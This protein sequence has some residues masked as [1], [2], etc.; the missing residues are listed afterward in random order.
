MLTNR[1]GHH[2]RI[3]DKAFQWLSFSTVVSVF[4]LVILGGVVRVTESGLG[5]PDWPLCHGK[6]IPDVE[7]HA[8]IEYSHRLLASLVT[9]LVLTMTVVAW[10]RYKHKPLI[11]SASVLSLILILVQAG[12]GAITVL[13]ELAGDVVMAHLALAE[14]L[15]FII[16]LI[17][18][19]TLRR[20]SVSKRRSNGLPVIAGILA[21]SIFLFLEK[22]AM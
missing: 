10:K 14:F 18:V 9:I 15:L 7:L 17:Y 4:C 22:I 12:L 21:F 2:S 19:A 13:T 20:L 5:C 16:T 8:V 1:R 11:L 6:V 3:T